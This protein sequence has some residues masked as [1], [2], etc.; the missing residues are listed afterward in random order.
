M[1]HLGSRPQHGSRPDFSERVLRTMDSPKAGEAAGGVWMALNCCCMRPRENWRE[2]IDSAMPES[3]LGPDKESPHPLIEAIISLET[4]K[5]APWA[6]ETGEAALRATPGIEAGR[7]RSLWREKTQ[8]QPTKTLPRGGTKR[9]RD[10]DRQKPWKT[11]ADPGKPNGKAAT[12]QEKRG[13][14]RY[15]VRDKGNR[16]GGG[17]CGKE[18]GKGQQKG[19]TRGTLGGRKNK[20]VARNGH[21]ETK[22]RQTGERGREKPASRDIQIYMKSENR[23]KGKE[24]NNKKGRKNNKERNRTR[25]PEKNKGKK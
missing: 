13:L 22:G 21:T 15:G 18:G 10:R 17:R 12:L 11:T 9:C 7:H 4:D 8:R 14:S 23:E 3:C 20:R 19:T 24:E 1:W 16:A 2:D 6:I 25:E 5:E